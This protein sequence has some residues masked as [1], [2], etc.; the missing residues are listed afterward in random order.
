MH[1]VGYQNPEPFV[2]FIL[3]DQVPHIYF[4]NLLKSK[5]AEQKVPDFGIPPSVCMR[6]ETVGFG[7]FFF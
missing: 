4:R 2:W 3:I 1:W 6:V 5:Q 7:V